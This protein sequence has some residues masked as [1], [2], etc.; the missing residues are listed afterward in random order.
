MKNKEARVFNSEAIVE[1]QSFFFQTQAR[2]KIQITRRNSA[3]LK[4]L[5]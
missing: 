4:P 1:F 5:K 3:P 2:A